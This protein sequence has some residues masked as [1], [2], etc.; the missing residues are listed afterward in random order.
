MIVVNKQLDKFKDEFGDI[1]IKKMHE[2]FPHLYDKDDKQKNNFYAEFDE[3]DQNLIVETTIEDGECLKE[4][5]ESFMFERRKFIIEEQKKMAAL[6]AKYNK[7]LTAMEKM[8]ADKGLTE[9]TKA[10]CCRSM[11]DELTEGKNNVGQ[12]AILSLNNLSEQYRQAEYQ[13][14]RLTG[15]FGCNPEGNG[16]ACFGYF[17]VDGEQSRFYKCDFIGIADEHTAKIADGLEARWKE[18][19]FSDSADRAEE[20]E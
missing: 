9:F 10:D 2:A 3:T 5:T 6:K 19:E 20:M 12:V 14:F 11:Y 16:R 1:H 15:G 17:C 7:Q 18:R 8:L 13:L 4:K